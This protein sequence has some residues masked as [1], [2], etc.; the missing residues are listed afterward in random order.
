M[1]AAHNGLVNLNAKQ[2]GIPYAFFVIK[3][4]L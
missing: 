2:C 4:E 3:K 1:T